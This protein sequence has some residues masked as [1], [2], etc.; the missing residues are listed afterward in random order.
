MSDLRIISTR[1]AETLV[2]MHHHRIKYQW[3]AKRAEEFGVPS[4]A[5]RD[6]SPAIEVTAAR[7]EPPGPGFTEPP[8]A[9]MTEPPP[10]ELPRSDLPPA[11]K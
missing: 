3:Q 9:D 11:R 5:V 7:T 10:V 4:R 1:M 2:N 8:P 6:S